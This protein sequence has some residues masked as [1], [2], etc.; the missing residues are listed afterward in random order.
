MA[1]FFAIFALIMYAHHID[2]LFCFERDMVLGQQQ[3]IYT[4]N[5][6]WSRILDNGEYDAIL[7]RNAVQNV[8][9]D[10]ADCLPIPE[11]TAFPLIENLKC[12]AKEIITNTNILKFGNTPAEDDSDL[13]GIDTTSFFS[14]TIDDIRTAIV[15]QINQYYNI[16]IDVKIIDIYPF[17]DFTELLNDGS[18][19]ILDQINAL[20]GT[21]RNYNLRRNSRLFS[22][23]L[24]SSGQYAMVN[25][26]S[27]IYSVSDIKMDSNV[28]ICTGLLSIQLTNAY[29]PNAE[30]SRVEPPPLGGGDI[31]TCIQGL[32]N[33]IYDV[34]IT[35]FPTPQDTQFD[36][37]G[38]DLNPKQFTTFSTNIVAGTPYW[39][40]KD[41]SVNIERLKNV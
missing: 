37:D 41:L 38:N 25:N 31:K 34:Y 22:C 7:Q 40:A 12:N 5:A 15:K 29:F 9:V 10:I 19:D 30:I 4:L 35:I 11:Y 27:S 28:R 39:V 2:A 17:Q 36:F 21:D 1:H 16:T 13:K 8:T 23:S 24:I 18:I 26:D 20:G 3:L 6:A 33:N 32:A 14:Q